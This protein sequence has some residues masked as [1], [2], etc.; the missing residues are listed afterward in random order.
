MVHKINRLADEPYKLL[1]IV[2]LPFCWPLP[3]ASFA[4]LPLGRVPSSNIRNCE[5]TQYGIRELRDIWYFSIY[6]G[7]L[8]ICWVCLRTFP[9]QK[10]ACKSYVKP[11]FVQLNGSVLPQTISLGYFVFFITDKLHYMHGMPIGRHECNNAQTIL[12]ARSRAQCFL[13]TG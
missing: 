6:S 1:E 13:H 8:P 5:P 12:I 11:N 10:D 3:H 4:H 9:E 2:Y 7:S